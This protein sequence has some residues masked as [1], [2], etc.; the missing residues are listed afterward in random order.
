[1]VLISK[2][3]LF[4][5][6]CCLLKKR[7]KIRLTTPRSY[8]GMSHIFA[9]QT[10]PTETR[11]RG[12]ACRTRT[13]K[14]RRKLSLCK[15]AQICGKPGEFWPQRRFAVELRR[16]PD[17]ARA[18]SQQASCAGSSP[19]RR[20]AQIAE[21]AAILR[22]R[23]LANCATQRPRGTPCRKQVTARKSPILFKA[24][25]TRVPEPR[26]GQ[27]PHGRRRAGYRFR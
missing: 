23:E 7:S 25:D 8:L 4:A 18:R 2:R 3:L 22:Q 16:W 9:E 24:A 10:Q 11:L 6:P 15:I 13:Q 21:I 20:I 27:D 14:C 12:W 17:A 5:T 26:P 19:S 1:V